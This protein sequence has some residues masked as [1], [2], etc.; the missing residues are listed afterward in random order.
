MTHMPKP[1]TYFGFRI[2][3]GVTM[4]RPAGCLTLL[5]LLTFIPAPVWIGLA[6]IYAARHPHDPL[7]ALAH[8]VA[9][10]L[11]IALILFVFS[12]FV[13]WL[14]YRWET[15]HERRRSQ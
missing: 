6:L 2:L 11:L 7:G 9:E 1:P 15:R 13:V 10:F 12:C 5:L 8:T 14:R 4:Y 3:P